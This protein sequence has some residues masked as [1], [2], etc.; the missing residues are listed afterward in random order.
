MIKYCGGCNTTK[1]VSEFHRRGNSYKSGCKTCR[2]ILQAEWRASN[3]EV[4]REKGRNCLPSP[5]NNTAKSLKRR[6]DYPKAVRAT[7]KVRYALRTGKLVRPEY[8]ED[9]GKVCKVVAHHKDY[10]KPLEVDWL[11]QVCHSGW[12]IENGPGLNKEGA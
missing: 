10:D 9:C 6:A 12:H 1:P 11:R 2:N 3:L 7:D 5:S 4:V 8:C